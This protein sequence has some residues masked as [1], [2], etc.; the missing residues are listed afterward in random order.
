M[1]PFELM[2]SRHSVRSYNDQQ[3]DEETLSI[4]RSLIDECNKESGLHIQLC[5]NQGK[6]FESFLSR[7]M[8]F[9]NVNNYIALTGEKSKNL[10]ENIGY[11]GEKIVLKATE[12]G[13]GTCWVGRTYRKGKCNVE[14]GDDEKL[15]CVI[16]IGYSD[17]K[18]VPRKTK[19][20]EE[21]SHVNGKMPE[22]FRKGMEAAQLAPTAL[23]EQKFKFSL[24]GNVVTA[25]PGIGVTS[26]IDMGIA[27]YHFELGAGSKNWIWAE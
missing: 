25:K 17:T 19:S 23:N 10:D 18:G 5:L 14:L 11:Y 6:A 4:L 8:K 13:L 27:K 2:K 7:L 9:S 21:L 20:I 1:D 22:W 26:K 3:M 24:D 16:T 12:L 15:F